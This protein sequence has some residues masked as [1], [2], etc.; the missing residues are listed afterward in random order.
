MPKATSPTRF[1]ETICPHLLGWG[2]KLTLDAIRTDSLSTTSKN[3]S[4][5]WL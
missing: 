5:L 3:T 4:F 2:A 1:P